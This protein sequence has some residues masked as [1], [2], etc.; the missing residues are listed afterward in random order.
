MNIGGRIKLKTILRSYG[1]NYYKA[2]KTYLSD[3]KKYNEWYPER[4]NDNDN[5]FIERIIKIAEQYIEQVCRK[6]IKICA[7]A[8]MGNVMLYNK[9]D[10]LSESDF[11][12]KNLILN[13][14]L[15]IKEKNG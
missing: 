9:N 6:Q 2:V 1:H 5:E 15:A 11:V 8:V 13:S 4:L 3:E 12:I 7:D 10:K 14:P